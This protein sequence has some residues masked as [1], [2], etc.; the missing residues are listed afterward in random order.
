MMQGPWGLGKGMGAGD[1]WHGQG[2]K[3]LGPGMPGAGDLL[4]MENGGDAGQLSEHLNDASYAVIWNLDPLY[5]VRE[6]SEHLAEV[7]F[8]PESVS[9]VPGEEIAFSLTFPEPY[10]AHALVVALDGLDA[11]NKILRTKECVRVAEW[12]SWT[13]WEDEEEAM[14]EHIR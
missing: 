13:D 6:L 7:D 5:R 11:S 4:A 1:G 3:N 12:K 9:R 8:K 10:T 2:F 14:P